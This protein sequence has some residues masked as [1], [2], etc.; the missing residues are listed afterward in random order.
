MCNQKSFNLT[1]NGL[2]SYLT[3]QARAWLS[4]LLWYFWII[5]QNFISVAQK[6]REKVQC[7]GGFGTQDVNR[8]PTKEA[9]MTK[10]LQLNPIALL[11]NYERDYVCNKWG[12]RCICYQKPNNFG[13]CKYKTTVSLHLYKVVYKGTFNYIETYILLNDLYLQFNYPHLTTLER[14]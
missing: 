2:F 5:F 1:N 9:C 13:G 11:F 10:C 8:Q 3:Y 7:V 12:C 6:F 14:I 4:R